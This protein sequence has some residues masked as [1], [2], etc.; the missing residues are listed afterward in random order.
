MFSLF[1]NFPLLPTV[2]DSLLVIFTWPHLICVPEDEP[3][4]ED[5]LLE[6]FRFLGPSCVFALKQ[7]LANIL[8]QL[9][10]KRYKGNLKTQVTA[11]FQCAIRLPGASVVSSGSEERF[12]LNLCGSTRLCKFLWPYAVQ[13]IWSPWLW[14]PIFSCGKEKSSSVVHHDTWE[15]HIAQL[16]S[17]NSSLAIV[18]FILLYY[19]IYTFILFILLNLVARRADVKTS[20]FREVN[21]TFL[22]NLHSVLRTLYIY[23]MHAFLCGCTYY[24]VLYYTIYIKF[25]LKFYSLE[26]SLLVS[27]ECR[28]G[29][30]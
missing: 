4:W 11:W 6:V 7:I 24:E 17:L 15:L 18:V 26:S 5:L 2:P 29:T 30:A 19:T 1:R 3:C 8:S 25:H 20:K 28:H 14:Q 16:F 12:L 13:V 21:I 10:T 23:C 27:Q 9:Q 22:Q